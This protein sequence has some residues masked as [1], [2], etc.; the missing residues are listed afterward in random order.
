MRSHTRDLFQRQA[1]ALKRIARK[2]AA[3]LRLELTGEK[4]ASP[5]GLVSARVNWLAA[6][7]RSRHG[8]MWL[9]GTGSPLLPESALVTDP[10][11]LEDGLVA[12]RT[13]IL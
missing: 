6:I 12:F 8:I 2:R 3:G 7:H 1:A 11:F 4:V 9:A 10:Q 5:D 13:R